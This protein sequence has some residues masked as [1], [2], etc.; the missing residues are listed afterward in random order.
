MRL[1]YT[2][3]RQFPLGYQGWLA[4]TD[5]EKAI[6]RV[7]KG[8]VTGER[9]PECR[10]A[11][12]QQDRDSAYLGLAPHARVFGLTDIRSEYLFLFVYNELCTL[13]MAELPGV[14][15]LLAL[16]E[17]DEALKARLK[18][19]GIAAGST[20]RSLARMRKEE[21]LKL[22]LLADDKWRF[23][24]LLG[25][26]DLPVSYLLRRDPAGWLV[27]WRHAGS[28]GEPAILASRLAYMSELEK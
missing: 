24:E 9:F 8:P 6:G 2:N 11:L 10:F 1:G 26:P 13:C 22:V 12:L 14:E 18:V 25:R 16:L 5:P 21:G 17:K 7:S 15:R 20:K 3:V 4:E 19:L 23:F 27:Q 28:I